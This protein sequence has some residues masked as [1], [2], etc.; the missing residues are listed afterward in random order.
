MTKKIHYK[1][2]VAFIYVLVLFLDRMDLTIT[3]VA[4]PTFAADFHIHI[5]QTDW[6]ATSFLLALGVSMPVSGWLADKYGSKKIFVFSNFMFIFGSVLCGLA[7]SLSSLIAF[8]I[9]QGIGGGLLVPVGMSMTFRNFSPNEYPKVANYTLIP[10]LIAPSI[11]PAIGGL[12]LE[13]LNWHWIFLFH[14]PIGMISLILSCV[15]LKE[16]KETQKS[17]PFDFIGFILLSLSLSSLFCFLSHIGL[18]GFR[19][20]FSYISFSL[21]SIFGIA[22]VY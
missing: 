15:Y 13:R 4:M 18:Y 8:R 5:T 21:F 20:T 9:V 1:Y 11:A 17:L 14:F 19:N 6:I 10:T 16:D 12:I 22:F 3:N 7:W 2:L